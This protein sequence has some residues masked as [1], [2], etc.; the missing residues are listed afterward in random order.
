M[1]QTWNTKPND[2]GTYDVRHATSSLTESN[3]I[4]KSVM[5]HNARLIAAA[6]ELL[7]ALRDATQALVNLQAEGES[8]Y[9]PIVSAAKAAIAKAAGTQS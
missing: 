2:D 1:A 6:P 7:E 3:V 9:H 5:P 8:R 4:A